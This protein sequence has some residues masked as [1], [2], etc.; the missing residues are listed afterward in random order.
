[1]TDYSITVKG[2]AAQQKKGSLLAWLNQTFLIEKLYNKTGLFILLTF[3]VII[4]AGTVFMGVVF[5]GI[6]IGAVVALP[7]LYSIVAYPRFGIIILL[8]MAFM[9]WQVAALVPFLPIGTLMDGLQALLLLNVLIQLKRNK[10]WEIFKSPITKVL[11]IWLIYNLLEFGNPA[12]ESRLA[13]VYTVRSVAVVTLSYFIYL[14]NIRSLKYI[15]LIFRVWLALCLVGALYAYKQEYIGFTAAEEAYLNNPEIISLLF[16]S[17]HWRKFSIFSDPVAF[18]YN[19]V[20]PAIFCLCVI[21]GKFR[22]RT[23][24]IMGIVMVLCMHSMLFSGTRGAN[25]LLPGALVLYAILNYNRKVLIFSC[26]AAVFLVVLINVPT[27][28]PN[29][30]RFQTAFRPNN[31]DSY[32]VRKANQKRIQPYILTHP[33]GGGLGATGTWGKRFAPGSYLAGFPPDSGYMRV[34]VEDGW[35]GLLIFCTLIFV[36]VKTGIE[37]YY[38]MKDPELKTYCLAMTMVVFA[39][40]LA[41]FPQEALVQYPSNVFFYMEVALIIILRRLDDQLTLEKQNPLKAKKPLIP[42]V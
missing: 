24:I 37:N 32:K 33:M 13:W 28:N 7:F 6:L 1:M 27:S 10:D 30:A 2:S 25:V 4:G 5:G 34:A 21:A 39:Y 3:A 14:Y 17:G 41:N 19:M 12:A 35:I 11:L 26:I 8:I 42:A 22:L 23:K 20:M 9:L 29:I 38:A 40:N 16:I 36:I 31:D 18:A 15:K